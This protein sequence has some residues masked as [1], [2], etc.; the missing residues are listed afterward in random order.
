[1]AI[2]PYNVVST[3]S[4][5][6]GLGKVAWRIGIALQQ[7]DQNAQIFDVPVRALND[8]VRSLSTEC[9]HVYTEL[10]DVVH[11]SEAGS[12]QP[13]D[14]EDRMWNCLA[15]QVEET[16]RTVK[17]LEQFVMGIRLEEP[18]FVSQ[19]QRQ[20]SHERSRNHLVTIRA[21]LCRHT[22]NLRTTL[23]LVKT[24]LDPRVDGRV[25]K[26]LGSLQLM[27]DKLQRSSET[28]PQFRLSQTEVIL[29]QCAREV[30]A[31]CMAIHQA[32]PATESVAD[33]QEAASGNVHVAR[34]VGSLEA[35]RQDERYST[36]PDANSKVLPTV[37]GQATYTIECETVTP[38]AEAYDDD[39]E[40]DL[41]KAALETG[42]KAFDAQ[43]WEEADS[44]LHEALQVIRKLSTQQRSFCHIFGL[45]YQLAVCAYHTQDTEYA[46]E[47]LTS[48]I[49]QSTVS[50]E[51]R[52]CILDATHLL[53]QLYIR[54]G[55]IEH[56]RS[57]CERALNARRRLLGKQSEAALESMALMAH[58]HVLLNNHARAKV[59]LAL[60][61]GEKR[62]AILRHVEES[63]G[64][65]VQHLDY[66]SLLKL[67][68]S[69]S[70]AGDS[71]SNRG[72]A[73]S[74]RG[75]AQSIRAETLSI[76]G[77]ARSIREDSDDG[78][79]IRERANAPIEESR[80]TEP[81]VSNEPCN[82][83][84]NIK[85]FAPSQ[86]LPSTP[87][88]PPSQP[89]PPPTV[90]AQPLSRQEILDRIGCQPR[91][92]IEEAACSGDPVTLTSLLNKKKHSWRF[93]LRGHIRP[94]RVTALHFAALFGEIDMARRLLGASFHINDV[95]YGYSTQ[96]TPLKFAIGAR[97][98][99]M[100]EFL[101]NNGARP[102]EPDTWSSL[103]GQLMSVSWLKKTMSESEKDLVP[104]RIIG[105]MTILL[106]YGWD[107]NAPY[108]ASGKTVL[109][110]AVSFWMGDYKW[111]LN[112]RAA[113]T[114]YLCQRSAN[115][116]QANNEGKTPYDLAKANGHQDLLKVIGKYAKGKEVLKEL[117]DL[118]G[119]PAELSS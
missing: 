73:Q 51:E 67:D 60:V 105:V 95:P 56:A 111:D 8:E 47:A 106:K 80:P 9:D 32:S 71:R 12:L 117:D 88:E 76:R 21:N 98:V 78:E 31:K 108:E 2:I 1:M 96:H 3:A 22:E 72:D 86:A 15:M 84:R 97:Q 59:C 74:I 82:S 5:V 20:R 79:P 54:M 19:S 38:I 33:G 42:T 46:E 34:W 53:S 11:K 27:I 17:D 90:Q 87:L 100:V 35:L 48:L 118:R 85:D 37:P 43:E 65:D 89:S 28:I 58:I 94:E 109:H 102:T 91:D 4:S 68:D 14:V 36:T 64:P 44:L 7:L 52:G 16:S 103:A 26:D 40:I 115:P 83:S 101:I 69:R 119:E 10:D 55:R 49:Q 13:H 107:I 29:M 110:Q 45:H 30:I 92:A 114:E 57:Q 75:D 116:W 6:L 18:T 39:L 24:V 104:N 81:V 66:E 113:V 77:D 112:L 41:A 61:P 63:L 99:E 23:L 25:P 70:I 50:D 62:E 93:K